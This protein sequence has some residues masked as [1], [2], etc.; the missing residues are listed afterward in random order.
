MSKPPKPVEVHLQLLTRSGRTPTYRLR[1]TL[2][3]QRET[4]ETL[5][6]LSA[7][8]AEAQRR[9]R[10]AEILLE[11]HSRA[12]S[13][14]SSRRTR[15]AERVAE[16]LTAYGEHL[17]ER[18]G[19]SGYVTNVVNRTVP[20]IRL[21]GEVLVERVTE[22]DLEDYAHVRKTEPG[23]RFGSQL[24][25]RSV[26]VDELKLLRRAMRWRSQRQDEPLRVPPMPKLK[27]IRPDAR[28]KRRLT[29]EELSQLLAVLRGRGATGAAAVVE[30]LAWCPRRPVAVIG[31]TRGD[32][33]RVAAT[34]E[35]HP[36]GDIWIANDKGSVGLGW[37]PLLPRARAVLRDHLRSSIGPSDAPVFVRP[38]GRPWT[39][40]A[41]RGLLLR[42]AARAGVDCLQPYDLR[43]FGVTR[44]LRAVGG[45][46]EAAMAFTGHTTA[47]TVL[48]YA[49]ADRSV[50]LAAARGL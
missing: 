10:E 13:S 35:A 19:E 12:A 4:V 1:Y 49:Y 18:H 29:E 22:R 3:G 46:P 37:C 14:G 42:A 9:R 39:N 43:R 11:G 8:E 41:L 40:Q 17:A 15:P 2:P 45:D 6:P 26:I 33:A 24:P 30:F 31:L 16:L 20:L 27:G 38:D 23:G 5:G 36:D 21:L 48:R 28:P 25:R 50:V 34:G 47:A 44:A 32:C 7:D